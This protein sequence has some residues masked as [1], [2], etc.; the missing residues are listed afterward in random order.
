MFG[1][2]AFRERALCIHTVNLP[3]YSRRSPREG[4]IASKH[5]LSAHMTGHL[6]H[7]ARLATPAPPPICSA[8]ARR[9]RGMTMRRREGLFCLGTVLPAGVKGVFTHKAIFLWVW[10]VGRFHH[11]IPTIDGRIFTHFCACKSDRCRRFSQPLSRCDR[12]VFISGMPLCERH[13]L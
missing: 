11:I 8:S 3:Q 2:M 7:R 5:P 12:G 10:G 1:C 9:P 13:A 4:R 6:H